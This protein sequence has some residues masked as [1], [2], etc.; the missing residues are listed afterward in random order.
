[1]EKNEFNEYL[2]DIQTNRFRGI[3]E[4][5]IDVGRYLDDID[6]NTLN[7]NKRI[8][9][10]IHEF[11]LN[12]HEKYDHLMK[13]ESEFLGRC[14]GYQEMLSLIKSVIKIAGYR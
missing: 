4:C 7:S 12:R 9:E 11:Y 2:L 3:I 6:C 5:L 1:M 14:E 13:K 10:V 8:T